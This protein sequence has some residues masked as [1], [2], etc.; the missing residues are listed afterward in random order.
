MQRAIPDIWLC[1]LGLLIAA[2]ELLQTG[3]T[4]TDVPD[5]PETRYEVTFALRTGDGGGTRVLYSEESGEGFENYIDQSNL[6]VYLL[7]GGTSTG[8]SGSTYQDSMV[9]EKLVQSPSDP[10][11]YYVQGTVGSK[12][13]ESIKNAFRILVLAN[14]YVSTT[15]SMQAGTTTVEG[16]TIW[17]GAF[18][19]SQPYVPSMSLPIPMFGIKTLKNFVYQNDKPTDFGVVDVVRAVAKIVVKS[20]DDLTDVKLRYAYNIGQSAPYYIYQNTAYSTDENLN[21]TRDRAKYTAPGGYA[22]YSRSKQTYEVIKDVPF[23]RLDST[24]WKNYYVAYVPEWRN[25]GTLSALVPT[26]NNVYLSSS[27]NAVPDTI[28]FNLRGTP[29][30]VEFKDYQSNNPFNIRRNYKYEFQVETATIFYWVS[31]MSSHTASPITF[32]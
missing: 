3:C 7:G 11:L 18:P 29:G 4:D 14:W 9:I 30:I 5:E 26:T 20:K 24:G 32:D 13:A 15:T 25:T 23:T 2:S 21:I 12:Q 19:C 1:L 22:Y 31:S 10:Q 16:L 27:Y 6:R 17:N 8:N 28:T